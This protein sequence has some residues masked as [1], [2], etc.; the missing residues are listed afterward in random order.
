M[1][2]FVVAGLLVALIQA[3]PVPEVE[4][5]VADAAKS[6]V[7]KAAEGLKDARHALG[8]LGAA[9]KEKL[10]AGAEAVVRKLTP[11]RTYVYTAT[12]QFITA[13]GNISDKTASMLAPPF[14]IEARLHTKVDRARRQP[15]VHPN[16]WPNGNQYNDYRSV[17]QQREQQMMEQRRQQQMREHQQRQQQERAYQERMRQHEEEARRRACNPRQPPPPAPQ[18][19]RKNCGPRR[20]QE[21]RQ[22]QTQPAPPPPPPTHPPRRR[23]CRPR[24]NP[25]HPP[26]I[27]APQVVCRPAAPPPPPPQPQR[28]NGCQPRQPQPPPTYPPY[29]QQQYPR[30]NGCQPAPPP[31]QPQQQRTACRPA[32]PPPQPQPY[33]TNG[34]QQRTTRGD[35]RNNEFRASTGCVAPMSSSSASANCEGSVKVVSVNAAGV[36]EHYMYKTGKDAGEVLA[37]FATHMRDQFHAAAGRLEQASSKVA[38]S[39]QNA[40]AAVGNAASSAKD[41]AA[42]GLQKTGEAIG[43]VGQGVKDTAAGAAEWTGQMFGYK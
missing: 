33:Y 29:P 39:A 28:R 43:A 4:D 38:D 1:R 32:P 7:D 26:P 8:N 36:V 10:N 40:A 24:T 3:A 42:H 14:R 25:T 23:N 20:V 6:G 22:P 16:S 30:S 11:V 2:L 35:S 19:R 34:C 9:A 5:D 15:E 13:F 27:H 21:F 31:P 18:T 37:T 41:S 17:D 12:G